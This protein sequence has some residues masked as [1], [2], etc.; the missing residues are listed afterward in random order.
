MISFQALGEWGRLGNQLFQYAFLRMTARRL[1]V[2]YYRPPWLGD[3]VFHLDDV[4]E[5]AARPEGISRCY[6]EPKSNVGFNAS[7]LA[8]EDG[9][10]IRGYFQS[11]RYFTDP[12]AVRRWYRFKDETVKEVRFKYRDVDFP[13]SVGVHLRF[14]DI[15]GSPKYV[16]VPPWYYR[17]A[18]ARVR[19]K[20]TVLV[21][22]DD[23]ERA[24]KW[25]KGLRDR[26]IFVEGNQAH[27]DLY[28][29]TQ[30]HDFVCSV[31]TLSWWGAW[32]INHPDKTVVTPREWFR[33][34]YQ[35]KT[36]LRCSNWIEIRTCRNVLDD[37]RTILFLR[38]ARWILVGKPWRL[39]ARLL[40]RRRVD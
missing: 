3:Q 27:E 38:Q 14:G 28:L 40:G 29:M 20:K 23:I 10:D 36:D 22:S 15:F 26:L 6:V 34:G 33:P 4:S 9:T 18:L 39:V 19:V 16:I 24:R 8:I 2:L 32:L 5:R 31:S 21:F 25:V 30:C 35:T 17:E 37:Y 11:E 7:A 1:K 13:N 12:A